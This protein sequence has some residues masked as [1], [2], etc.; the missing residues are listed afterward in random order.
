MDEGLSL[1][2]SRQ[3]FPSQRCCL[4]P[5]ERQQQ[6]GPQVHPPERGK[7]CTA[8]KHL[9]YSSACIQPGMLLKSKGS[10]TEGSQKRVESILEVM[11]QNIASSNALGHKRREAVRDQAE[12]KTVLFAL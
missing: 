5:S 6:T 1:S 2:L 4:R 3:V 7:V 9:P 10:L 8:P 11:F 12:S